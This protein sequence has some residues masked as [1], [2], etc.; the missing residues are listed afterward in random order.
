MIG[1]ILYPYN[2][3][4]HKSLNYYKNMTNSDAVKARFNKPLFINL[5]FLSCVLAWI[6]WARW[7]FN[8][9]PT[10]FNPDEVQALANAL[11]I[12][13]FGLGWNAVDGATVGPL[14]FLILLIP[15][16]FGFD[17]TLSFSRISASILLFI[18]FA[19]TFLML[20]KISN[21][22]SAFPFLICLPLALFYGATRDPD[23]SHLS[24][25]LFPLAIILMANYLLVSK[26][27]KTNT[28]FNHWVFELLVGILLGSIF[29]AKLQALPLALLISFVT[30]L[31]T[32]LQKDSGWQAKILIFIVG[33]IAPYLLFFIPMLI[34][35]G[36]GNFYPSYILNAQ[37]YALGNIEL[38]P[39]HKMFSRD[40]VLLGAIYF[41]I[42]YALV[43]FFYFAYFSVSLKKFLIALYSFTLLSLSIYCVT[44]P[45]R[46]FTHYLALSVPF[47]AIACGSLFVSENSNRLFQ[48]LVFSVGILLFGYLTHSVQKDL[49]SKNGNYPYF[50]HQAMLVEQPFIYK[51]PNIYEWLGVKNDLGLIW[52]WMPQWYLLGGLIPAGRETQN[53]V[54]LRNDELTGYYRER[55]LKDLKKSPP[56]IIV[57]S[58]AGE[59]FVFNDSEKYGLNSFSALWESVKSNYH[60]VTQ[61]GHVNPRCPTIYLGNQFF[62]D[63]L[64]RR[65]PIKAIQLKNSID[66]SASVTS[67]YAL[68][69]YSVTEDSCVDYTPLVSGKSGAVDFILNTPNQISSIWILNSNDGIRGFNRATDK[70]RLEIFFGGHK[71]YS[72][73]V[74]ILPYP[75]WT[76]V[77]V[78]KMSS[79]LV[80]LEVV[81]FKGRGAS[82]NEVKFFE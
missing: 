12:R 30:I 50:S 61:L 81:S 49:K 75:R 19:L 36:L 70:I 11:R 72:Q 73:E 17:P 47:F 16:I 62:I 51:N 69:D 60:N 26:I 56:T 43:G 28:I 40:P 38:L 55:L 57:D 22:D 8:F 65:I 9:L 21:R 80:T 67:L 53:E 63:Y 29:F 42:S 74:N 20:R 54:Q 39:L 2:F 35:G 68:D 77:I 31:V 34:W 46:E 37:L 10:I 7:N 27:I 48:A 6:V 1:I 18:I 52:G 4:Y 32:V 66:P 24:S 44:R 33:F 41:W 25:E 82:L 78:P 14:N 5:L 59:S 64:K 79:D 3:N 76:K 71:Q 23:F 58:V 15:T 13:S 45:G